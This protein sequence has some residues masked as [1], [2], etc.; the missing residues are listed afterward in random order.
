MEIR[1]FIKLI[2]GLSCFLLIVAF[3][4]CSTYKDYSSVAKE[5]SVK[6]PENVV[7]RIQSG[8]ALDIKFPLTPKHD[9]KVI[10]RPDGGILLQIAGEVTAAGKT[11]VELAA[12]LKRLTSHRL[13]NPEVTVMV[14][15]SSQKIFVG[16]EVASQGPVSYRDNLTPLQAITERGGFKDTADSNRVFLI[17]LEKNTAKI[18]EIDLAQL[19][20]TTLSANDV[21]FVPRTDVAKV[22]LAVQQY[23]RNMWPVD[24]RFY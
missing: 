20:S 5:I 1:R 24:W 15:E 18:T 3:G 11:P 22:N 16:G 6:K 10:V 4:G 14:A 13:K 2:G 7:Y 12:D 19:A 21:L 9:E 8:D 23:I 17:K